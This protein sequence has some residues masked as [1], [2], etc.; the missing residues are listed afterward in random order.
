VTAPRDGAG[1]PRVVIC[2]ATYRRPGLLAALLGSLAG[3]RFREGAPRISVVVV[4]NDAQGS[5]APVLERV[6]AAGFP[7]A[8]TGLVQ[9]ERNISLARNEGVRWALA[10][11][12]EWVAF[13]D[14]D[15]TVSPEWLDELL[16]AQRRTGARVVSGPVR[17]RYAGPVPGWIARGGFFESPGG[18]DGS[19]R[20]TAATNNVL[21]D[22]ALLRGE[23]GPFD[24]RFG[25]SGSG[26][27]LFFMHAQR[28][29]ARIVWAA[30]A[31]VEETVP[32]SRARGGW[33]LRRAFRVGNGALWCERA[34]DPP[35]RRTARRVAKGGA[36]LVLGAA[37]LPAALLR[38]RRGAMRALWNVC[39]GAGCLAALAGYRYHEYR[40]SGS[41]ANGG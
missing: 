24:P 34:L 30:R 1:A 11:G 14:D 3:V 10:R 35:L 17:A 9:A 31:W 15:E 8:L 12:A 16:A 7:F 41:A 39:Y 25:T 32:S 4:D 33:I 40:E 28:R 27:S 19:E 6:R 37:L 38:G 13:V 5:A 36:R 18:A 20:V 2:I 29:G 26:D 23:E 21:V 22:A